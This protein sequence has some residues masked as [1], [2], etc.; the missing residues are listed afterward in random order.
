MYR[1]KRGDDYVECDSAEEA[2]ELLKLLQQR[3]AS[4]NG[5]RP[6]AHSPRETPTKRQKVSR[7]LVLP[8]LR[9]VAEAPLGRVTGRE[10]MNRLGLKGPRAM[11]SICSEL[12][13]LLAEWGLPQKEVVFKTR[14]GDTRYWHVGKRLHEVIERMGKQ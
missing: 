6:P 4:D 1:V 7:G 5:H 8:F 14:Q 11:G 10:V 13:G 3:S 9:A 12:W 2:A